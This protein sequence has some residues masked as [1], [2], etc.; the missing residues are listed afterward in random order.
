MAVPKRKISKSKKRSRRH[1]QKM[2]TPNIAWD[3]NLGEYRLPHYVSQK[4]VYK[5]EE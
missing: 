1:H 3:P 5:G 2:K 4:E